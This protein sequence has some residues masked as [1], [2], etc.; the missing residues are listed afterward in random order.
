[1][2]ATLLIALCAACA[3]VTVV[4]S[5]TPSRPASTASAGIP[6]TLAA[7]APSS[8]AT[9]VEGGCGTTQV[10]KGSIPIELERAAGDNAPHGL[11]VVYA[12]PPVLAGFV[13]G[14]PLRAGR[15]T[16]RSNKILW[17]VSGGRTGPLTV[18][19]HPADA[20]QPAVH[21]TFPDN[22][23]PGNIYPS[24]IDVP[25]PGCWH[26]ALAWSGHTAQLDLV[27]R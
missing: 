11:P 5:A 24:S 17:V 23:G 7:F 3:P 25:T 22:S 15:P 1:M 20:P 9:I 8:D 4:P 19:A 27:Y 18:D 21:L 13:F 2:R 12:D 6:A 26:V 10:W 14:Y 16:D